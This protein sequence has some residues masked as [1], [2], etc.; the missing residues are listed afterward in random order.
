MFSL[1]FTFN[2]TNFRNFFNTIKVICKISKYSLR[3]CFV[4]LFYFFIFKK[5]YLNSMLRNFE[6]EI[7]YLTVKGGPIIS[8]WNEIIEARQLKKK[9]LLESDL[10]TQT[11]TPVW[12]MNWPDLS[13]RPFSSALDNYLAGGMVLLN[14][15]C[16][17]RPTTR[18]AY[19]CGHTN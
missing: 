5:L 11:F 7:W 19:T 16:G 18:A 13:E 2:Y 3:W 14:G 8:F 12:R 10:V 9:N 1:V 15:V 4:F 6:R 17:A